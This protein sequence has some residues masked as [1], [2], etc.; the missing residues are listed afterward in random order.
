M[1]E[2]YI[3]LSALLFLI[4]VLGVLTR[5]NF[6]MILLSIEIML[7]AVSLSFV[8]FSSFGQNV[9][10]QVTALLIVAVAACEVAIGLAI[11][12]LLFRNKKTIS[13]SALTSLKG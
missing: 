5:R 7:N 11:A 4:G 2:R 10:G 8:A 12:V 13:T 9:S 6:I 1:L 3:I